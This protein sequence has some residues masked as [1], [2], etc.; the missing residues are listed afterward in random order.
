MLVTKEGWPI[1]QNSNFFP[2]KNKY[3]T[4]RKINYFC[5]VLENLHNIKKKNAWKGH[6]FHF[7]VSKN[8]E[9]LPMLN[10]DFEIH[11]TGRATCFGLPSN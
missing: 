11:Y 6:Q 3:A 5:I 1:G 4:I 8:E 10:N 7:M 2:K 9:I